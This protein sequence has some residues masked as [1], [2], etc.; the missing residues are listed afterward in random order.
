MDWIT[1]LSMWEIVLI[2][3]AFV[4]GFL[5]GFLTGKRNKNSK[6]EWAML[7][8]VIVS[9]AWIIAVFVGIE[10]SIYFNVIGAMSAMHILWEKSAKVFLDFILDYKKWARK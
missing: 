2:S 6:I 3:S 10:M 8:A 4:A 9:F 1:A 5:V 7:F